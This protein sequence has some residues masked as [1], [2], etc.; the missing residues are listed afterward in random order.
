MWKPDTCLGCNDDSSLKIIHMWRHAYIYLELPSLR[1]ISSNCLNIKCYGLIAPESL[2]CLTLFLRDSQSARFPISGL[3]PRPH[4]PRMAATGGWSASAAMSPL[5]V[6]SCAAGLGWIM[7]RVM[8][9][10]RSAVQ[11]LRHTI[12][13]QPG[14]IHASI[15]PCETPF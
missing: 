7:M 13:F 5:F 6:P 10:S 12:Q 11:M 1:R 2:R 14:N 15:H 8:R 3:S 9:S 4:P